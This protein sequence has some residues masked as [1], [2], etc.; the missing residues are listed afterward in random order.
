[1]RA[2]GKKVSDVIPVGLII[3][4]LWV[5]MMKSTSAP[6]ST[7]SGAVKPVAP[8]PSGGI[9]APPKPTPKKPAPAKP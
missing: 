4:G 9:T 5:A 2:T 3:P 6:A 1:V 8:R 7:S